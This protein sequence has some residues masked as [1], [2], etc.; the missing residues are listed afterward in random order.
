M[1]KTPYLANDDRKKQLFPT[2]HEKTD[3][4]TVS[5]KGFRLTSLSRKIRK[6]IIIEWQALSRNK[7][8]NVNLK[9]DKKT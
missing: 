3:Y 1:K 7:N 6:N 8:L 2:N 9:R 5:G 4:Q